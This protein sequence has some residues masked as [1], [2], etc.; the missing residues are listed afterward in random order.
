MEMRRALASL[1]ILGCGGSKHAPPPAPLPPLAPS[2]LDAGVAD[3][4]PPDGATVAKGGDPQDG[5]EIAKAGG[6]SGT[7]TLAMR[8]RSPATGG[9]GAGGGAG[10]IGGGKPGPRPTVSIGKLSIFGSLDATA[11]TATVR[12]FRGRFLYC[13]ETALLKAPKLEGTVTL[14]L[15]V[16]ADGKVSSATASGVDAGVDECLRH[17]ALTIAFPPGKKTAKVSVPLA[18]QPP[19]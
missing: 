7:T 1:V 3:A 16:E 6:G 11:A 2:A 10:A 5:G 13:Y 4:A 19:P 9:E 17:G 8:D 12:K 18:F 14:E 15:A